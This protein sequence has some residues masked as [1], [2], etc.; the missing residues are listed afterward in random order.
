MDPVWSP[1]IQSS[2]Q[3]DWTLVDD[4]RMRKRIQNR[5]AQRAHR[6]KYGRAPRRKDATSTAKPRD[7]KRKGRPITR[8]ADQVASRQ[9]KKKSHESINIPPDDVDQ[10]DFTLPDHSL[11][12]S[13]DRTLEILAS[14]LR[15]L[16]A[17]IT[18]L[19][20]VISPEEE[21]GELETYDASCV[22]QNQAPYP[23][24]EDDMNYLLLRATSTISALL[25]NA[26]VLHI[27]CS[28]RLGP[29]IFVQPHLLVPPSLT[30]LTLQSTVP[31]HPYVDLIP[32]PPLRERL[33]V[34]SDAVDGREI[35]ND[36]YLGD[37][38][39]WG[40]IPWEGDSWEISER[41]AIKWWF[42]MSDEVLMGTNFWRRVRGEEQL[43]MEGIKGSFRKR[44]PSITA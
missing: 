29:G 5:L 28:R 23:S 10:L 36:M 31:H 3:D 11:S 44:L 38:K 26:A 19:D 30:P 8:K 16:D 41:F 34:A 40:S 21:H 42:L 37:V 13:G 15:L 43:T 39:V 22:S 33:L 9:E 14:D 24:L 17:S 6:M 12:A 27:D 25:A 7:P 18:P 20:N 32:I 4:S 1:F 35:W 2:E